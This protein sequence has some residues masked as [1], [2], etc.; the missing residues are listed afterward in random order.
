MALGCTCSK[1][2]YIECFEL[3]LGLSL[4]VPCKDFRVIC[5]NYSSL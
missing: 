3:C 4:G 1:G 2:M 5:P